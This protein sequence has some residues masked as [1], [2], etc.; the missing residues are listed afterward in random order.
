V[1]CAQNEVGLAH[2]NDPIIVGWMHDDEPDNAQPVTDPATGKT[3][4]GPPCTAE[5]R[6]RL[7]AIA[8]A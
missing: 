7:P 8:R 2:K 4:Y 3:T 6:R 1:I 5:D